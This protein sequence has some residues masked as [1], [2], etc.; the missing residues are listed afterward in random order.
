MMNA[1][2]LFLFVVSGVVVVYVYFGYP[3]LI[4]IVSRLRPRPIAKGDALPD[5]TLVIAVFNEEAVVARKIANSLA[6]DYPADRLEVMFVSD[7]STDG[8][9]VIIR[10]AES[11]AVRLLELPRGGKA[12]ALNAGAAAARGEILLFTDANVDLSPDSLR[13]MMR[14]FADPEVGGVSGR[15]KY[16]VRHGADTTEV[17]ENL[18][19]RWDQWQKKLES[20]IGS[21][22]AADGTLYAVRRSLYVPIEDPAQADDIAISARVVLQGFRLVF[23][24][25]AVAWEEAPVEG[26]DEFRRK[27]RVTNHSVRALLNLG[28]SLWTSGFYSVELI[29]HKLVRH[30]VPFFLLALLL[31]S[32]WLAA[33]SMVFAVLLLLQ[34]VFY[35]IALA[36]AALRRTEL[37]TKRVFSVPYY[38]CLVNAAA[39]LGVLGIARGRRV[40]AWNPR[41]T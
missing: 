38:F 13:I 17:G 20:E 11:P 31:S 27:V 37:G 18:Y 28:P 7:G 12:A 26:L 21:I 24:P 5:V 23:E 36:G 41:S 19:W 35:G 40:R 16:V 14:S 10:A 1:F 30:L 25:E 4:W 39:L 33:G 15:K 29:S 2:A 3:L 9:A 22:F 32:L 6:L 34:V 8:T